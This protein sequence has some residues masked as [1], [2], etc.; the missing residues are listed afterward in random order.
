M[1]AT[2]NLPRTRTYLTAGPKDNMGRIRWVLEESKRRYPAA[3]WVTIAN[4]HTY[5]IPE[6][7]LCYLRSFDPDLSYYLGHR[8]QINPK[9]IFNSGVRQGFRGTKARLSDPTPSSFVGRQAE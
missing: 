4:D 1:S 2:S 7:A 8:L 3:A 9:T 5:M 6:N